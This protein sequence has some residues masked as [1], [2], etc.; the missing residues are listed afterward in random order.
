MIL[1]RILAYRYQGWRKRD[2][3]GIALA[4]AVGTAAGLAHVVNNRRLE[5]ARRPCE[6]CDGTGWRVTAQQ[7]SAFEGP[8]RNLAE[9]GEASVDK[10]PDCDGRGWVGDE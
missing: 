7:L 2:L 8:V 6:P 5:P 1:T 10:C 9:T 3:A 4:V